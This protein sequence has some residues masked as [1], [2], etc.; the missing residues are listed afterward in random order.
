M[1]HNSWGEIE[2]VIRHKD[3]NK[4]NNSILNLVNEPKETRTNH[5]EILE[6]HC[7]M[8]L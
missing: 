8:I 6:Y 2:G 3:G 4:L 5:M 7:Q 1:Y